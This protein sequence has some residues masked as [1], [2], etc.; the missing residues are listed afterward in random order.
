VNYAGQPY[1]VYNHTGFVALLPYIEQDPLFKTYRYDYAASSSSPYTL[2]VA[3]DPTP[4]PNREVGKTIIRTYL[5]P[6]DDT[7]ISD[8][9]LPRSTDFYEREDLQ[10]GNYLFNTGSMTDYNAH[11]GNYGSDIR[12]GAF[13]N[14]G[15][16][17]IGRVKDGTS[18]TIAIG[19]S[20]TQGGKTSSHYGPWWGCGTHTA[21]HGYTPSNSST[22]LDPTTT[23]SNAPNFNVNAA[24]NGDVLGR[25]YAWGFGSRHSGGANFVM[26]DGSVRFVSNSID[27]TTFCALNY[28][29]DRSA[30]GNASN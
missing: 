6:A 11:W 15:A 22:V 16:V 24:Y 30:Y 8:T 12:R 2:P 13:G 21:V 17:N 18:N 29:N 27:Y 10:R 5:C 14:D 23:A 3:P 25:Q 26:L 28:I 1:A 20:V 4:N 9:Y 7:P 19:E